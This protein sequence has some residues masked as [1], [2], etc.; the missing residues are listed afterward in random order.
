M[1]NKVFINVD[2]FQTY[3]L[4]YI[5]SDEFEKAFKSTIFYGKEHSEEFYQA[6]MHG[7]IWAGLLTCQCRKICLTD[8][9]DI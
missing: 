4:N 3:L 7:I 2:E 8:K 5:Q 9:G 6:M 1:K